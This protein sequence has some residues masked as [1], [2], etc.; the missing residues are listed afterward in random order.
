MGFSGGGETM[1]H[2]L[3][4]RADLFAAY[5]HVSSQWNGIYDDVIGNRLPV[6]VFMAASDEY[7]GAQKARDVR[8]AL[9]TRYASEGLSDDE[10]D[11]LVVLDIPENS[12]FN[13]YGI[14]YYH[15]GGAVAAEKREIIRW[16]LDQRK[17]S[18]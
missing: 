4:T 8:D 17:P 7:Y 15:G 10:V 2:V 1:S 6:Y 14:S 11:R 5:V 9:T 12:Y 3:N 18:T 16:V 13:R